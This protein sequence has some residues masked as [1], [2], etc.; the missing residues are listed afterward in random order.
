MRREPVNG[1]TGLLVR[2]FQL[3][4]ALARIPKRSLELPHLDLEGGWIN[5][6]QTLAGL[7]EQAWR[8]RQQLGR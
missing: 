7:D 4:R 2:R 3:R 1:G 5:L 8:S 6:E